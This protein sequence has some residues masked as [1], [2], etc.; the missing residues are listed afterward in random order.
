MSKAVLEAGL[1][2]LEFARRATLGFAEDVPEDKLCHAPCPGLNHTLWIL[3]HL[4]WTDNT[5]LTQVGGR[6]PA[7]PDAWP[8]IFGMKTAPQA[9][10]SAYPPVAEVRDTLAAARESLVS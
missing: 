7:I 4:A 2:R 1:G 6:E 10:R 5:F 3:G 9:D 8:G